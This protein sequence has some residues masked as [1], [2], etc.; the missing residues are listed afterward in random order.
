MSQPAQQPSEVPVLGLRM[1]GEDT[2]VSEV[3]TEETRA[4]AGDEN[5]PRG[6]LNAVGREVFR[7]QRGWAA[8]AGWRVGAGEVSELG[9]TLMCLEAGE[10]SLPKGEPQDW[11]GTS[12]RALGGHIFLNKTTLGSYEELDRQILKFIWKSKALRRVSSQDIGRMSMKEED[13]LPG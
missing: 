2:A 1:K 5:K 11:L 10:D 9:C 8:V 13:A 3:R 7:L 4:G 12:T 6:S